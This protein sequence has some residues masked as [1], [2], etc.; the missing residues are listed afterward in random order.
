M[1]RV[2]RRR[3]ALA[4]ARRQREWPVRSFLAT[5]RPQ[6]AAEPVE[7]VRTR[8]APT[9]APLSDRE[10]GVDS[11]LDARERAGDFWLWV[12]RCHGPRVPPSRRARIGKTP[13]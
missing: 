12:V 8:R 13:A 1:E 11:A 3:G 6:E 5:N 9:L 7:G 2:F 4:S 10:L